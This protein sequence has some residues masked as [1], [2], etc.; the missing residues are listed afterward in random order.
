MAQ[1]NGRIVVVSTVPSIAVT[2]PSRHQ[3]LSPLCCPLLSSTSHCHRALH[4]HCRCTI[5]RCCHR[6]VHPL[7]CRCVAIPPFIT[8][9]FAQSI[10]VALPLRHCRAFH[11][12]RCCHI[13]VAPSIAVYH[14]RRCVAVALSLAAAVAVDIAATTTAHFC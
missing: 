13:A 10:A 12:R 11:C 5:H 1:D 4:C 8:V 2:L 7:H 3:L 6:A 14:H 9:D